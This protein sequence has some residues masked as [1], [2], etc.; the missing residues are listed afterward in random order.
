MKLL[1]ASDLHLS[2]R[3]WQHRPIAGDS[4]HSWHQL[5]ELALSQRVEGVILA[6]DILDKQSNL[7]V[8]IQK[9]LAG[10][11][12]LTDAGIEVYYNQGQHE[13]QEHPWMQAG[14]V[15]HWLHRQVVTPCPGWRIAGCDYQNADRFQEF[16]QGELAKSADILVCHQVWR[17]FMGDVGKPQAEFADVPANVRV[18]ITGDYHE[19]ICQRFGTLTVLSP[20]STHMR[21]IAEP[22]E[23][24]C[25]T[26]ELRAQDPKPEI[27]S[28]PLYTRRCIRL[29]TRLT[30]NFT[31]LNGQA[32]ALLATAEAYAQEHLPPELALPL[33]Q[34]THRVGEDELVQRFSDA[35]RHRGH[36][37]FKQ[38]AVRDKEELEL[39]NY[40]DPTDRVDLLTCLDNFVDAQ[41]QSLQHSLA[42]TLLQSPDPEQALHRWISEQ[43]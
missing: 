7:S 29:D 20:G 42:V 5:V 26:V 13:Y 17:D 27:R 33:V 8:P 21:S 18:L 39:I 35:F 22:E 40:L 23:H 24:A 1:V 16:L 43:L 4:Y 2:D 6:G 10:L 38:V 36:L 15:T 14:P 31:N 19:H 41:S 28:L 25:F 37:F 12:R 32:E 3:V 34:L 9:L 30:G 11:H